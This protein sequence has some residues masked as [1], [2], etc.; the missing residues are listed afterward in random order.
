MED[1]KPFFEFS[2]EINDTEE[3]EELMDY[4]QPMD[5]EEIMKYSVFQGEYPFDTIM[6]GIKNQFSNYIG[7]EDQT[8]YVNAFY[9]QYHISC[10]L[11]EED[12][13][14][15]PI[16][17]RNILNNILTE[18]EDT[19]C[20]L[21]NKR[22]AINITAYDDNLG[23]SD[24]DLEQTLQIA[25]EFFILNAKNNFKKVISKDITARIKTVIDKDD[26]FFE[27]VKNTMQ[28]YSPL[29][30]AIGPV[31]FLRYCEDDNIIEQF[32]ANKITGNFLRKYSP[33]LYQFEEFEVEIINQITLL[34]EFKEEQIDGKQ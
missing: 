6:E 23:T 29:V 24:T 20:K 8:N 17:K 3:E 15:H 34:Q 26:E 7:T 28:Y 30:I 2:S 27:V 14:D 18:F 1:N 21:F 16:E 25:Y 4:A 12:D 10:K 19:I 11:L 31:E 22:L 33:R 5:Y 32:N 13:E 9:T